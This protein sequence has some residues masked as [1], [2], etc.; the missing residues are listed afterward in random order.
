MFSQRTQFAAKRHRFVSLCLL[1]LLTMAAIQPA[2]LAS[3]PQ[4]TTRTITSDDFVQKRPS[5]PARSKSGRKSPGDNLSNRRRTYRLAAKQSPTPAVKS[6]LQ[7]LQFGLTIWKLRPAAVATANEPRSINEDDHGPW[8]W[9]AEPVEADA[10][11]RFGEYL[12]VSF[13]SPRA[14]YLYVIDRDRFVDGKSG[15]TN[16]IFPTTDDDNRLEAGRV[17]D[18]PAEGMAPFKAEP[19]PNQSGE[20]LTIIVSSEPLDLPISAR[21]LPITNQQLSEWK[22]KWAC[23]AERFEMEGGAGQVRTKPER[24]VGRKGVRQLT[25]DDPGPQTIYVLTPKNSSVLLFEVE[26]SY[27]K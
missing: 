17:I 27:V 4:E 2:G 13:E 1:V 23:T 12:R 7:Q 16:L 5:A 3:L 21:P 8:N 24:Q 9:L 25:R 22:Q 11:F 15:A 14:G 20:V 6:S 26:L 18:I 19:G 10:K